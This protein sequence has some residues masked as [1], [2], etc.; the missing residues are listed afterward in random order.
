MCV[1]VQQVSLVCVA[2]QL[3]LR[4][5]YLGSFTIHCFQAADA[6]C[7]TGMSEPALGRPLKKPPKQLELLYQTTL[8]H[9]IWLNNACA[10][11]GGFTFWPG[12]VSEMQGRHISLSSDRSFSGPVCGGMGGG[13]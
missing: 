12:A 4:V 11:L 13:L 5:I 6:I 7:H 10:N 8:N 3:L 2:N 9:R 1:C